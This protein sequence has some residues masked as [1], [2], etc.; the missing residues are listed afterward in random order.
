MEESSRY[1]NGELALAWSLGAK[2]THL[3]TA[4]ALIM[5]GSVQILLGWL[6][7]LQ[8]KKDEKVGWISRLGWSFT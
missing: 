6:L 2:G 3:F 5:T 1:S 8:K 7:N 4:S